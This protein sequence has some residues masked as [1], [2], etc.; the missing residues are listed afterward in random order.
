MPCLRYLACCLT[1]GCALAGPACYGQERDASVGR[2]GAKVAAEKELESGKESSEEAPVAPIAPVEVTVQAAN[3]NAQL[4]RIQATIQPSPAIARLAI[5]FSEQAQTIADQRAEL[6]R[7]TA[8]TANARQLED[9]RGE[10]RKLTTQIDGWTQRADQRWKVLQ[11]TQ[12]ELS[13]MHEQWQV[14]RDAE[15][16]EPL[17]GELVKR[18]DQ[19]LARIETTQLATREQVDH[20]GEFVVRLTDARES[21]NQSLRR[22]D[23]LAERLNERLLRRD[24]P[25]LWQTQ[26]AEWL[27]LD[28]STTEAVR[29]WVAAL[30]TFVVENWGRLL[31]Q[32]LLLIG[33]AAAAIR[34]RRLSQNWPDDQPQLDQARTLLSRPYSLAI[35]FTI[36][37]SNFIYSGLPLSAREAFYVLL[38]VPMLRL[39]T[40]LT[41]KGEKVA[42]YGLLALAGLYQLVPISP[43]GSLLLRITLL[44]SEATAIA[45]LSY[46]LHLERPGAGKPLTV[47]RCIMLLA[48][49]V[50][51]VL[52]IIALSASLFGWVNLAHYLTTATLLTCQGALMAIVFVRASAGLLPALLCQGPGRALLS[53]RHHPRLYERACLGLIALVLFGL[54]SQQTLRRFRLGEVVAEHAKAIFETPLSWANSEIT[55]GNVLKAVLLLVATFFAQRLLSFLLREEL[56]PRLTMR[57]SSTAVFVTLLKYAVIAAGLGL[58]GS[59]LGFSATQLTV[60]FGALGVGIGFGLQD[61]TNNFI[62]GLILMFERPIKIGDIIEVN[63]IWGTV[64]KVG[65]RATVVGAFEGSELV[66]P[67]GDLIS[68]EVKNWTLSD[69]TARVELIVGTPYGS[70]PREVLGILLR[71]AKEN[72]FVFAAPEPFAMMFEFGDSSLN[73]RLLCHTS[74][75]KRGLVI[76]QLHIAVYEALAEAGI[77][78]PIPQR[79]L[80][81]KSLHLSPADLERLSHAE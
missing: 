75:D 66:V 39:A 41:S 7:L 23:T 8:T 40:G 49:S 73:F 33:L 52:F 10:W 18:I 74:I 72:E 26:E 16:A 76:S 36:L 22:I 47:W 57:S 42:L 44:A 6:A 54:W 55:V 78:I 51:L 67:N 69:S 32:L 79:D 19:I 70:D 12:E 77:E 46:T 31:G 14:T 27:R 59:A 21:A 65:V 5:E 4:E 11:Q 24:S 71:V 56:F 30:Q 68:K 50:V 64:K 34:A 17:P 15:L 80:H 58:A 62:S 60:L 45:I 37:T 35:A 81:L 29:R 20:V 13:E 1:I 3:V 9:Q 25:P 38:I 43:E 61:I 53:V 28:E 48:T 63:G 2:S